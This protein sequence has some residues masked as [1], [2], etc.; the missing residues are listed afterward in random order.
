MDRLELAR[1]LQSPTKVHHW[2]IPSTGAEP[3]GYC[4]FCGQGRKFKGSWGADWADFG[5]K[6]RSIMQA[7]AE[8]TGYG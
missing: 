6:H 3:T 5:D 7:I 8:H 2:M 1:C 4:Q